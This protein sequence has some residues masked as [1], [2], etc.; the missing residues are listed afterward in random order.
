MASDSDIDRKIQL[1][2]SNDKAYVWDVEGGY[3]LRATFRY[4]LIY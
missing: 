2:V 3:I 4:K 1:R